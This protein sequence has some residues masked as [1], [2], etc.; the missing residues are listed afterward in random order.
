VI[1]KEED[2]PSKVTD[3]KN[4]ESKEPSKIEESKEP[5]KIEESKDEEKKDADIHTVLKKGLTEKTKE[6]DDALK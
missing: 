5:P 2:E 6:E 4:E 3:P 1:K